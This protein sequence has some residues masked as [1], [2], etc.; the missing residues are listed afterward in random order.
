MNLVNEVNNLLHSHNVNWIKTRGYVE[1][2]LDQ[3]ETLLLCCKENLGFHWISDIIG[4]DFN[5]TEYKLTYLLKNP[6]E[7]KSLVV[8]CTFNKSITVKSIAPLWRHAAEFEREIHEMLGIKFDFN[9]PR[10]LFPENFIGY[11]L[12]KSFKKF[13][14]NKSIKPKEYG[15]FTVTPKFPLNEQ[16]IKIHLDLSNDKVSTCDIEMG[17]HHFGFEKYSEGKTANQIM[18]SI[19]ILSSKTSPMW[20]MSWAHLIEEGLDISIPDKAMG[21]RMLLNELTRVKDHLYTLILISYECGYEDFVSS[22]TIWYRKTLEQITL[23]TNNKNS[24][25]IITVGG[26]RS[27][28]PPGWISNCLEFLGLLEKEL[29]TEYKFLTNSSFWFER[30][31]CGTIQR[32]EAMEWGITGPALRACGVNY[33]L[34]KRDPIYFYKDVSFDV[35][36]GINGHI[37]DRFLVLVEEIFQSLKIISQVLENIPTGK[38]ISEDINSFYNMDKKADDFDES[39]FRSSIYS[40]FD[41]NFTQSWSE[42]ESSSGVSH[43][44]ASFDGDIVTRLKVTS[45][46]QKL[47]GLFT[48]EIIN[49]KLE[50]VELFWLSLGVK[51]SEVEK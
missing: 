15:S 23:L 32:K 22:L 49:E 2:Q 9:I 5:E 3:L 41:I 26:V 12:L 10:Y 37:Y 28:I 19:G 14:I 1:T 27:D 43:I 46:G 7:G 36:L 11:P 35:P 33:D 48:H 4:N 47:M 29:L 30:L 20:T 38:I 16:D 44:N 21:I 24:S 42:W 51:M 6:E 39:K 45:P 13:E 40:K 34:R 25:F 31:Q 50:D 8:S 17:F 18:N